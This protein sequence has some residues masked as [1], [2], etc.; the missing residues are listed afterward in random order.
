MTRSG[1]WP[2]TAFFAAVLESALARRALLWALTLVCMAAH[3]TVQVDHHA[4]LR[5]FSISPWVLWRATRLGIDQVRMQLA[6]PAAPRQRVRRLVL[7][8]LVGSCSLALLVA[9]ERGAQAGEALREEL[10]QRLVRVWT[11]PETRRAAVGQLARENPEWRLLHALFSGLS[12]ANLALHDRAHARRYL[13]LLERATDEM[14]AYERKH[15]HLGFLLP[16]GAAG[17]FVV[18]P[19]RS[20]FVD[21]EIAMLL[22][23]RQLVARELTARGIRGIAPRPEYTRELVERSASLLARMNESPV[24]CAESY[25]DECWMFC[26]VIG[27]VSLRMADAL[28]GSDH[29][30]A[31]ARF[32]R[33]ARDALTDP[34]TGLLVS[35]YR[36][37]G[38]LRD[39]PEG[40]TLWLAAHCLA[41]LDPEL[42][43]QQYARGKR[44]LGLSFMGYAAAR[45]WPVDAEGW[46]D[47]DVGLELPLV[48]AA[49]ASSGFAVLAASTFHDTTRL[50]ELVASIDFF[51]AFL[52]EEDRLLLEP[53]YELGSA[54][55][56][57]GLAQG[58]LW[59]L[60]R[61]GRTGS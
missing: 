45:E 14:R 9:P 50:A 17:P 46:T 16:Y 53:G 34:R 21:G 58:P 20:A 59:E 31:F 52:S 42:A 41:L 54:V 43:R 57:Y 36:V 32:S 8:T 61:R 11:E 51:S 29:H 3:L 26:T 38:S 13:A 18:G 4:T 33:I 60:L 49:A 55:V 47:I 56:A 37:D 19:Q 15:G 40:S 48:A 5:A 7:I 22:G 28:T 27:L 24:A 12:F 10:T 30:A 2:F 25:P 39:G 35:S 23:A 6:Q 1:T 44:A